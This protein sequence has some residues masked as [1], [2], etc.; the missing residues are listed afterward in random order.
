MIDI[1]VA[2]S[3]DIENLVGL[4]NVLFSQEVEFKPDA[5]LQAAGLSKI[6]TDSAVGRILI[7][8]DE[9]KV[10]GM[11]NLLYTISTALGG[12][13][14]ILED[15][16][17]DQSARGSGIG[18]DLLTTAIEMCCADGCKRITL[19]TDAHNI[20]AQRFYERVGFQRSEMIPFRL[21]LE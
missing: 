4:L 1:R 11:V 15:M 17:V 9:G 3:Q 5:H 7:A 2:Q 6:I 18:S 8:V 20:D 21:M 16:V 13:V 14:A 12:R 19:L 10:V